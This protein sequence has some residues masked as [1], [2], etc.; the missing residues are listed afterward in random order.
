MEALLELYGTP[1]SS[2]MLFPIVVQNSYETQDDDY[3]KTTLTVSNIEQ[4]TS[5]NKLG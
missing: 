3:I 2:H 5:Q 1:S 4:M